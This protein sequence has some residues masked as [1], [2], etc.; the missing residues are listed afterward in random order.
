MAE[1]CSICGKKIEETFLGKLEGTIIKIKEG[2]K[3][4]L[5]YVCPEC[6]KKHKDK[7]KE[8]LAKS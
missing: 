5:H 6:Q 8:E 2:D 1:K 4:K 7:L 3:N